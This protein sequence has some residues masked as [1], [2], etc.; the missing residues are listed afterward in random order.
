[1]LYFF[2]HRVLYWPGPTTN[3]DLQE[4]DLGEEDT[5]SEDEAP[6]RQ[7]LFSLQWTFTAPCEEPDEARDAILG[8]PSIWPMAELC[9]FPPHVLTDEEVEA[10]LRGDTSRNPANAPGTLSSSPFCPIN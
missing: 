8:L 9:H 7:L 4:A 6:S 5:P 3:D 1:M 10:N 2:S